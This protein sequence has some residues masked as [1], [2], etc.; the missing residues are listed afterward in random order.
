MEAVSENLNENL[1]FVSKL[2]VCFTFCLGKIKKEILQC[3]LKIPIPSL[4]VL[5]IRKI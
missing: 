3:K 5:F 1:T 2:E 4:P